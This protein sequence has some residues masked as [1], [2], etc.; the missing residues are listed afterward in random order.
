VVCPDDSTQPAQGRF[1]QHLEHPSCVSLPHSQ[2]D[3]Q[4]LA[5]QRGDAADLDLHAGR[6]G[7]EYAHDVLLLL[8]DAL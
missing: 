5:E 2:Y 7:D 6:T 4:L 1:T 3:A 8:S